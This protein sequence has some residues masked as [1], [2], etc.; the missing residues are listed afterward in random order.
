[1]LTGS[2]GAVEGAFTYD[3]Y[4]N[5]TGSTGTA[6]TPLGYDGQLTNSDTELIYLRARTY[7]PGTGQF[8]SVD[9][10][11][12]N[13]REPYSYAGDN[14]LNATDPTGLGNWLNLG[15]P[16]PGQVVEALNP[17]KYYE[18]E[19]NAYEN[20]CSYWESVAH[21]LQGAVVGA[22]DVTGLGALARG[23]A[24]LLAKDV[25]IEDVLAGLQ[26]GRS[27]GVYV[28]DSPEQLQ[29][30]YAE[31]SRGG[32]PFTSSYPGEE[33]RLPDGTRVGIRQ[34]STSGGPTIDINGGVIKVHVAE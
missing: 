31:L 17:V 9:P 4:G 21:G 22:T 28:V 29:E 3:A 11:V 7:D 24:G 16:S 12:G 34:T 13:T 23:V 27:S 18:E 26:A 20:G 6:S 14:P 8:L 25:V 30:V 5:L 15:I 2:T 19:I 10:A 33:V 1:M 32:T